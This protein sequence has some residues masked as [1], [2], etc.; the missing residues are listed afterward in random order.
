MELLLVFG[1]VMLSLEILFRVNTCVVA[2]SQCRWHDGTVICLYPKFPGGSRVVARNI[3]FFLF[4]T[5]SY[6]CRAYYEYRGTC[7]LIL[8]PKKKLTPPPLPLKHI[9]ASGDRVPVPI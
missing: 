5:N 7:R 8:I 3:K 6:S 1:C 2:G 4:S 9:N